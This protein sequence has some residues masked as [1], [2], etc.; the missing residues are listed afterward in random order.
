MAD[1]KIEIP[2]VKLEESKP[3]T[4]KKHVDYRL[5]QLD[6]CDIGGEG[7]VT[8]V[9]DPEY[10]PTCIIDDN[11]QKRNWWTEPL[12][13]LDGQTCEYHIPVTLNA[14]G[15]SFNTRELRDV[16]IPFN[17]FKYSYLRTG[18]RTALKHFDKIKNDQIVCAMI[19]QADLP[20]AHLKGKKYRS[21]KNCW[22]IY[23]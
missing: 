14:D 16:K 21:P 3:E 12:P 8:R 20:T 19:P 4:E 9:E 15:K 13:Y 22:S 17:V 1:K 6:I 11:A 18:I 23:E 7:D 2:K 5:V 10:C